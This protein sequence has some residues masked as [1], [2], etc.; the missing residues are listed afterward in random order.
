M[1][2]A[3]A[4]MVLRNGR[5]VPE[6]LMI[7]TA[8]LLRWLFCISP[9]KLRRFF[10]LCRDDD[11]LMDYETELHLRYLQLIRSDGSVDDE[12]RW[13]VLSTVEVD[14]EIDSVDVHWPAICH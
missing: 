14:E 1:T 7:D 6:Q 8:L 2:G 13:I 9:D 11:Y 3:G 10:Y 4:F 12:I 5:V